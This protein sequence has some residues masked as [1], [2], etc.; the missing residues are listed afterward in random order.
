MVVSVQVLFETLYTV[1]P[2]LELLLAYTRKVTRV[3]VPVKPWTLK[4]R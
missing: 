3:I 4:R 1:Y 2:L